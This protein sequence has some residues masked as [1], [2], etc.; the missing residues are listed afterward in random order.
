MKPPVDVRYWE[1]RSREPHCL[2]IVTQHHVH[3][4]HA[5][6]FAFLPVDPVNHERLATKYYES[7]ARRQTR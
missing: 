7:Q 2:S 3:N 5:T 1:A 6:A 4:G